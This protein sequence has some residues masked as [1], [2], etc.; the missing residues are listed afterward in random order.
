MNILIYGNGVSG[1]ALKR[2][3]KSENTCLYDDN[4][5][6]SECKIEE[7]DLQALDLVLLSPSVKVDSKLVIECKK[8]GIPVL[9]E[10]EYCIN[11]VRDNPVI[12]V[13]GTN[14]KTTVSKLIWHILTFNG[15]TSHWVGNC[16][17]PLADE[18]HKIRQ[19]D[20]IV[21]ETSSFQLEQMTSFKPYVSVLTNL[22]AD[23]VDYHG[24]FT[25][26][27]N[28]KKKNFLTQTQACHSVFNAD[29]E[30]CVKLSSESKAQRLFYS[31]ANAESDCFCAEDEV[32]LKL[33][34]FE[35]R[36]VCREI[37]T[38]FLHNKSNV[39]CAFLVCALTGVSVFDCVNALKSFEWERH[40]LERVCTINNVVFIDDSKATNVHSAVSALNS[41]NGT[42]ALILGGKDKNCKFDE[43]F[44]GNANRVHYF[45][46]GETK[47]RL[48]ETA[49]RHNVTQIKCCCS[50]RE[51][52]TEAYNAVCGAKG[53]SVL[54]SP[55]CSSFDMFDNYAHR[56]NCFAEYVNAIKSEK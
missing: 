40:R 38:M 34:G 7:I 36:V 31:V 4:E 32:V 43:L 28:A 48:Y 20:I 49:K 19:D 8:L 46:Y 54:L 12:S 42:V 27:V 17:R 25:D 44:E 26:Y 24:S 23:H 41:V 14:G 55:A 2:L 37:G 51:A 30:N 21:C 33:F 11:R 15:I 1:K 53:G 52:T 56:G 45:C 3:L 9:S 47:Q 5:A 13:T 22:A 39:L 10:L 18:L 29:D 35:Q 16:G 50:L 6:E